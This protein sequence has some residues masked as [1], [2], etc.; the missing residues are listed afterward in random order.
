MSKLEAE[1]KAAVA[2]KIYLEMRGYHVLEQQWRQSRHKIDVIAKK[3][4]TI[5]L[6]SVFSTIDNQGTN[7]SELLTSS[8]AQQAHRAAEAWLQDQKWAGPHVLATIEMSGP[9]YTVMS[10]VEN[11]F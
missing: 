6:I 8:Y 7:E 4:G 1:R 2:A 3:R 10:F 5:Y 11:A 9:S